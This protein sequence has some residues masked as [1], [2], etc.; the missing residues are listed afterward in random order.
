VNLVTDSVNSS[1]RDPDGFLFKHAAL[2]YRQVNVSYAPHYDHL[3]QSGLYQALQ[4][5]SLLINH[6]EAPLTLAQSA[7]AYRILQPDLLPFI[8]YPYE[9]CFGQLRAAALLTLRIQKIAL[10]YGMSLKDATAYNVQFKGHRPVFIDTLSFEKYAKGQP[11]IAYRQFCQ[12][13]VAPLALMALRDRRMGQLLRLHIDGIPLDLAATLLPL[14]SLLSFPLLSHVH[15]HARSQRYFGA[16]RI[17]AG[18]FS[19][20][21]NAMSGLLENMEQYIRSLNPF[22]QKTEW[23]DYYSK[24]NYSDESIKH[25]QLL[26][27]ELIAGIKPAMLWDFGANSGLFSRIAAKHCGFAVAFDLDQVAVEACFSAVGAERNEKVL[28]L[29]LDLTNPSPAIGWSLQERMSL[30][31]RGPADAILALAIIHH[32]AIGNNVPLAKIAEF[33]SSL[34]R[35]LIV[36]FIPKDDSQVQQMLASRVDIFPGYCQTE[37]EREFSAFFSVEKTF[38]IHGTSRSL[39]LLRKR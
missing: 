12:H 1:F 10:E 35:W 36:E 23:A 7:K 15:L 25:K 33:F 26:V 37:F 16:K 22:K 17:K 6:Q 32:L 28:P 8:S 2:L 13:F 24:T 20:S 30:P 9:W 14:R 21:K 4:G 3:M 5:H 27:D 31:Q 38:P 29:F 18:A 34:C 11:W 19:I 39:Y